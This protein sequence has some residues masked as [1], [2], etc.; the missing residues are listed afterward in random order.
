MPFVST[1]ERDMGNYYGPWAQL[2][3][4]I[5]LI[6]LLILSEAWIGT[7]NGYGLKES[8]WIWVKCDRLV[9]QRPLLHSFS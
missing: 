4:I 3:K 5:G 2:G 6:A 7:P 1:H 9:R 8:G